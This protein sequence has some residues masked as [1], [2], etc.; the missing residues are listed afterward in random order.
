MAV[1]DELRKRNLKEL[2]AIVKKYNADVMIK[3]YSTMKKADL[4]EAMLKK[5]V[6]AK[7]KSAPEL[8]P[9][10]KPAA[11]PSEPAQGPRDLRKGFGIRRAVK[12]GGEKML[13]EKWREM[14]KKP[15]SQMTDDEEDDIE[16]IMS[17]LYTSDDTTPVQ[18]KELESYAKR[19][20][21]GERFITTSAQKVLQFKKAIERMSGDSIEMLK[22]AKP[23][24]EKLYKGPF[25]AGEKNKLQNEIKKAMKGYK[26]VTINDIRTGKGTDNFRRD[27]I[28]GMKGEVPVGWTDTDKIIRYWDEKNK[29]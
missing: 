28:P 27:G 25:K 29:R 7:I 6:M 4:I 14:I 1:A 23:A 20:R 21:I 22:K 10:A 11:K 19:S 24:I 18:R 12:R 3:R 26:G 2:R 9:A 8:K 5:E 13:F 17:E 16:E 15:R